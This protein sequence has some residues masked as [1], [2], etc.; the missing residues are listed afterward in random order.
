MSPGSSKPPVLAFLSYSSR[1]ASF[2][3]SLRQTVQGD[4]IKCFYAPTDIEPREVWR[5]RIESEIQQ[6]NVILL[7]YTDAAG[8]SEEVYFEVDLAHR[9]GKDIWLLKDRKAI[10]AERFHKFEIGARHH[11]FLFDAGAEF[12]VFETLKERLDERFGRIRK[13]P[14]GTIDPDQNPYPGKPYSSNDQEF[15]FGRDAECNQLLSDI[16]DGNEQVFL[17]YGPSGAGKS[18][19]IDAGLRRLLSRHWWFSP[20]MEP[21]L[22]NPD[23]MASDMWRLAERQL[24]PELPPSDRPES[25]LIPDI[26]RAVSELGRHG[27]VFWFDHVER[28]LA[29]EQRTH[30]FFRYAHDLLQQMPQVRIILSFRREFLSQAEE[31]AEGQLAEGSWRKWVMR[32]LSREG[33]LRSIVD[34]PKAKNGVQVEDKLA[35]ALIDALAREEYEDREGNKVYTVNPVSLQLVC[36]RLWS[37]VGKPGFSAITAKDL[38]NKGGGLKEDAIHFV[39]Q[40][41][42]NHLNDVIKKIADVKGGDAKQKEELIRLGLLQFV[43]EDRRR[44]QLKA[45]ND[46]K[47]ARV[48]RL[49]DEIIQGLYKEQ[50]LQQT[51]IGL[52]TPDY[53]Y[54]LV[55]DSL[56]EAINEF[57]GKIDLLRTLNTLESA[58]RGARAEKK[59]LSG[60]FNHNA[61]LLAELEDARRDE[62]GFFDD[63]KEFLFR[64]AMGNRASTKKPISLEGWAGLLADADLEKFYKALK[65][66][67]SQ[68]ADESVCRDA[69]RLLMNDKF[70]NRLSPEQ[71]NHLCSLILKLALEGP[72]DVQPAACV[73]VCEVGQPCGAPELFNGLRNKAIHDKARNALGWV[74]HSADRREITSQ[75]ACRAFELQWRKT[76]LMDRARIL[77]HLWWERLQRSFGWMF[78]VVVM[79]TALTA[80]GAFVAFIPMGWLGASLTLADSSAGWAKGPFHGLAGGAFW[81][82]GI[83]ASLVGYWVVVRGGRVSPKIR[84]WIPATLSASM[85]GFVAGVALSLVVGFVFQPASLYTAGWLQSDGAAAPAVRIADLFWYTGHGWWAPIL[86][87]AVAAGVA[88]SLQTISANPRAEEFLRKQSGAIEKPNQALLPIVRMLRLVFSKSYRILI[89]LAIGGILVYPI[90]RPGRGICD[91]SNPNPPC[92]KTVFLAPKPVRVAGIV[93]IIWAGGVFLEV[94]ILFGIYAARTGVILPRDEHFLQ[95]FSD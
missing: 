68:V 31:Q 67:L 49:Q 33:A 95:S 36:R 76:G 87:A 42:T 10:I 15:F 1:N 4:G 93:I 65:E 30:L 2:A 14:P 92:D 59:S 58:L 66:A 23:R 13:P 82:I 40:A 29:L 71:S 35:A 18:S 34:P 26:R 8:D 79:S 78:F 50:L 83:S 90:L 11:G 7:L 80:I 85:G 3:E 56:A 81:G 41:L 6:A 73:A 72:A 57:R 91:A 16:Y 51:D 38:P 43:T 27:Y 32:R 84:N 74:R 12:A 22:E 19:L 45:E 63:E 5:N 46:G 37:T 48:G 89:A 52:S 53:R 77:R 44:Q 75:D 69:I 70:R 39:E 47:G 24:R 21:A 86:G 94:G 17:V 9:L 20:R 62:T 54:E 88:W 60:Y 25:E 28:L 64:C 55:H 61:D